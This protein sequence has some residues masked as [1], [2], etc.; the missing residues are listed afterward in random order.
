MSFPAD[1]D[2]LIHRSARMDA[3]R[4]GAHFNTLIIGASVIAAFSLVALFVGNWMPLGSFELGLAL[5]SLCVPLSAL[6]LLRLSGNIE[7]S[8]KLLLI[9]LGFHLGVAAFLTGGLV[10]AYVPW[11][12]ILPLLALIWQRTR[13]IAFGALV[14]LAV[15]SVLML[16]G[17]RQPDLGSSAPA[18]WFGVSFVVAFLTAAAVFYQRP[19]SRLIQAIYGAKTQAPKDLLMEN[20][21][22]AI[23]RLKPDGRVLYVSAAGRDLLGLQVQDDEHISWLDRVHANDRQK[24]KDGIVRFGPFWWRCHA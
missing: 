2:L 6:I 4:A 17:V 15:M 20:V 24:V 10:S 8:Q 22:D 23:A 14:V 12:L 3:E 9:G 13:L 5:I 21:P 1:V 16:W 18:F 19:K 7:V 11:I